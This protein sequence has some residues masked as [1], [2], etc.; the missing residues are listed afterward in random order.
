MPAPKLDDDFWS[1]YVREPFESELKAKDGGSPTLSQFATGQLFSAHRSVSWQE[2][3]AIELLASA[4]KII[5]TQVA[6]FRGLDVVLAVRQ[7]AKRRRASLFSLSNA[8]DELRAELGPKKR[9][10][11]PGQKL[12]P[13]PLPKPSK[14]A[15]AG[16]LLDG[17]DEGRA[18]LLQQGKKA[19]NYRSFLAA[20]KHYNALAP[21]EEK[22][23]RAELERRAKAFARR[24][25]EA[26]KL[27]RNHS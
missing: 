2:E 3:A 8:L 22:E 6:E 5:E 25:S 12:R 19:T 1:D 4:L 20:E 7:R 24:V 16:A 21:K 15:L 9:G 18:M 10:R 27:L 17:L 26:R 11:K 14:I 13:V 23:S